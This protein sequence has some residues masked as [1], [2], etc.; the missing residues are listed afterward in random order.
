MTINLHKPKD[1]R[2]QQPAAD[3]DLPD[4]VPAAGYEPN[5]PDE[6]AEEV[7]DSPQD[8]GQEEPSA[9]VGEPRRRALAFP[10]LRPYLVV[11]GG[12]KAVVR[13]T[14]II[15]RWA[16]GL[17]AGQ[18][19]PAGKPAEK[20]KPAEP[21]AGGRKRQGER[22]TADVVLA[23]VF[24]GGCVA[25]TAA[26][27]LLYV[28]IFVVVV[29][30]PAAYLVGAWAA[31]AAGGEANNRPSP[32]AS[33]AARALDQDNV[34][35]PPDRRGEMG[36]TDRGEPRAEDGADAF[37]EPTEEERQVALY[38][39]VRGMIGKRN[40]VHLRT[41]L[42]DLNHEREREGLGEVSMAD[43]RAFLEGRGIPVQ[44]QLKVGKHNRSG[45]RRTD[46]PEGFT[47]LLG[48]DGHAVRL[49]PRLPPSDLR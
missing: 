43:L 27:Y 25:L 11:R 38:E 17:T 47:P 33:D 10:D 2:E 12:R 28:I 22:V 3:P 46:L 39:W 9:E 15:V 20:D 49:L 26:R 1:I 14:V 16:H 8:E 6:P 5:G 18:S 36:H 29:F 31:E 4:E 13:G 23:T 35:E 37:S 44:D 7:G 48:P 24:V 30:L 32:P 19:A 45:V 42:D 34:A 40:G 21:A 41:L